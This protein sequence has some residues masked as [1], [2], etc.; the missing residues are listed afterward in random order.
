MS[1]CYAE[2]DSEEEDVSA[3]EEGVIDLEDY[4][5]SLNEEEWPYKN[6]IK[7]AIE[8]LINSQRE[9]NVLLYKLHVMQPVSNNYSSSAL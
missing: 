9:K 3:D 7:C 8:L 5:I 2:L 4:I 6:K 1:E